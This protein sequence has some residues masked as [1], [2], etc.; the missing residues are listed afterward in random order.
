MVEQ[1]I[2]DFEYKELMEEGIERVINYLFKKGIHFS[3][4]C[5]ISLIEFNPDLPKS[6][7]KKFSPLTLFALAGYTFDTATID[8]G[9]FIFEAGFGEENIGSVVTMPLFAIF[10]I[11]IGD[12][13]IFF[14]PT[15]GNDNFKKA[16][17]EQ[18]GVDNSYKSFLSNP[19]N[20]KFFD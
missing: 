19:E 16:L 9:N 2:D 8:E 15:A 3:V 6:M 12:S 17:D 4:L 7:K 11:L 10:Q 5:N 14:N 1:V 13:I 18:K 20:S